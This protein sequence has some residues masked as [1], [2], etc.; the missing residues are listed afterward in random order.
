MRLVVRKAE[1]VLDGLAQ[2][3]TKQRPAILPAPLMNPLTAHAGPRE[4]PGEPE[5]VQDPRGVGADLDAGADFGERSRLFV[6]MHV[7]PGSQQGQGRGQAADA[8]PDNRDRD[9]GLAN[10]LTTFSGNEPI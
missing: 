6:H 1:R 4:L 7:E 8:A 10:H 5:T 3:R 9:V 2:R